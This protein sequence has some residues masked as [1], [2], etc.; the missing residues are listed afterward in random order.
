M[1]Q[2]DMNVANASGAVVRADINAHLDALVTLSSGATAPTTT[3]AFQWWADTATGL[4]KQRNAAN[5]AFI[6]IYTLSNG[7]VSDNKGADIASASPLVIGTDGNYFDV[8]GTTG[9]AAMTVAANKFFTLQFDGILTMTH[10]AV[11]I[12]LPGAANITTAAGD[13]AI[14][15]ATGSNTVHCVAYTRADG[16]S[17]VSTGG[18][19][20]TVISRQS[21]SASSTPITLTGFDS[22]LYDAYDLYIYAKFTTT[23]GNVRVRS[24]TDGGTGYDSGASDYKQVGLGNASNDGA[25]FGENATHAQIRLNQ[26]ATMANGEAGAWKISVIRPDAT[27][28]THF[29]VEGGWDD[30]GTYRQQTWGAQRASAADVDALQISVSAGTADITVLFIGKKKA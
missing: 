13:R 11:T 14:F 8:T 28:E 21:V 2:T 3:F 25:H 7:P 15:F 29:R 4:L 5:T 30:A 18:G 19:G 1:S 17:V 10:N 6:D 20:T 12:N 23:G 22:S 16:T 26:G 9:F 24:S 27:T